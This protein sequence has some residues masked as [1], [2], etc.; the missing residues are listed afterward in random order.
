MGIVVPKTE[1]S[2]FWGN[3]WYFS[4][5]SFGGVF[6]YVTR[7]LQ[8]PQK[9]NHNLEFSSERAHQMV[10]NLIRTMRIHKELNHT[11]AKGISEDALTAVWTAIKTTVHLTLS[12]T[13][14]TRVQP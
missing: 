13:P 3:L 12:A 1:E 10:H 8:C 7:G 14:T 5:I 11:Q 6:V 2:V 4:C 9:S